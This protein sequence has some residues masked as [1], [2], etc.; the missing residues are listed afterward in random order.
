MTAAQEM[1]R[2][3]FVVTTLAVGGGFALGISFSEKEIEGA[4]DS[5][6]ISGRPW[7]SLAG[8]SDVEVG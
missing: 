2:R 6:R 3:Q 1:S 4:A 5:P 7:E 8:K